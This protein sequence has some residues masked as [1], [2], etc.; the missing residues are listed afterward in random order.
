MCKIA[1]VNAALSLW[2]WIAIALVTIVGFFIQLALFLLA[3]P[4]DRRVAWPD[5]SSGS[6]ASRR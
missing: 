5:G 6:S 2:S 3:F 4:F 1:G